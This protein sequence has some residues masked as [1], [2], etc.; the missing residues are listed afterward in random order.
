[1]NVRIDELHSTVDA[2]DGDALLTPSTLDHIV[3]AVLR[4]IANEQ[5][6]RD[7]LRSDLD[8]RSIVEQQRRAQ[9]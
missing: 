6:G 4:A 2:V 8:T 5:R 3:K 7:A 1:M 9:A